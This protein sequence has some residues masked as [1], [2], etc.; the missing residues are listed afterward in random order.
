MKSQFA[1]RMST[2]SM[3]ITETLLQER[4]EAITSNR[5]FMSYFV[6]TQDHE[7]RIRLGNIPGVPVIYLNKVSLVMEAPSDSS[8]NFGN[9]VSALKLM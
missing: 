3:S 8:R 5:R 4:K 2:L 1:Y 7:L 6:A 9:I